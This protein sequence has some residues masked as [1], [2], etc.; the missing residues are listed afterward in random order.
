MWPT[1]PRRGSLAIDFNVEYFRGRELG[2]H[3]SWE[4]IEFLEPQAG[5]VMGVLM[6]MRWFTVE[7][8]MPVF[9]A[10]VMALQNWCVGIESPRRLYECT[11]ERSPWDLAV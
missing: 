11:T 5:P 7:L 4:R 10:I 9:E 8:S 6:P 3:S 2:D 1:A